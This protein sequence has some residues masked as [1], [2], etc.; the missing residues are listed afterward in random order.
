MQTA[1]PGFPEKGASWPLAELSRGETGK[2][3]VRPVAADLRA[4]Q[5]A[6]QGARFWAKEEVCFVN[7][8]ATV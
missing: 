8:H 2:L 5:G 7:L 1:A 3:G 4:K 6:K